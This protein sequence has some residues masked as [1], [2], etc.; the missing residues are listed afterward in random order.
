MRTAISLPRSSYEQI[1]KSRKKI[2]LS[3]SAFFRRLIDFWLSSEN[4]RSEIELYI[5]GYSSNPESA[6]ELREIEAAYQGAA[7]ASRLEGW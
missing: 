4:A 5:E 7:Q 2:R 3:R 1:E 6:L